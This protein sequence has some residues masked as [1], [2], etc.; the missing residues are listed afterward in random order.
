[1]QLINEALDRAQNNDG[2]TYRG[3]KSLNDSI[4]DDIIIS[5][6]K[7]VFNPFRVHPNQ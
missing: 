4:I 2:I 1:M 5:T 6:D 3:L 7:K